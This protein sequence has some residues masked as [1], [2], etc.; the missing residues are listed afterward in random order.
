MNVCSEHFTQ[1]C[2]E[3]EYRFQLLG[4]NTHIRSL[5]V[6]PFQQYSNGRHVLKYGTSAKLNKSERRNAKSKNKQYFLLVA[7]SHLQ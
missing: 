4:G 6:A 3:M 1:D 2:F 7:F 5:K